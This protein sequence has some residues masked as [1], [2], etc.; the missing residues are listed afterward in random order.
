LNKINESIETILEQMNEINDLAQTQ[1]ALSQQVNASVE[2]LNKMSVE[3]V[4]FAKQS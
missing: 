4:E 1:A 2:E 3:L